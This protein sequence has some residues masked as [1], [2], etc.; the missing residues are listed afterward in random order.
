MRDVNQGF[1]LR[2]LHN[3]EL[4]GHSKGILTGAL[5]LSTDRRVLLLHLT[6]AAERAEQAWWI[7]GV[8]QK[9][10]VTLCLLCVPGCQARIC[11]CWPRVLQFPIRFITGSLVKHEDHEAP[12]NLRD[13]LAA[14]A[15][16]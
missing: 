9:S 10:F 3:R 6:T 5:I 13:R 16:H 12:P 8:V 2:W 11:L 7:L 15:Y 4:L 1:G 14:W